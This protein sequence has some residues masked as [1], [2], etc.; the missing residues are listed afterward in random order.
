MLWAIGTPLAAFLLLHQNKDLLES[1]RVRA[2][3]GFLYSGFRTKAYFWESALMFRKLCV[4]CVATLFSQWG[5]LFQAYVI[6]FLLLLFTLW[7]ASYRPYSRRVLNRIEVFS[8]SCSLL[9][10]Y[11]GLY[12]LTSSSSTSVNGFSLS[13]FGEW[14]VFLLIVLSNLAFFLV[15]VWAL[16]ASLSS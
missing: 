2:R 15:W 1:E 8:L 10:I 14:T 13:P 4:V 3:Y 9:S 11:C 16:F 6:L 12:S 7:S 5:A